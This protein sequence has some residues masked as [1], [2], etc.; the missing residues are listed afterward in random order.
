MPGVAEEYLMVN[1]LGIFK[2]ASLMMCDSGLE[3]VLNIHL[4]R[5]HAAILSPRE[6]DS[7]HIADEGDR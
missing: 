3:L 2:P 1:W 7:R 5:R 4:R 6:T